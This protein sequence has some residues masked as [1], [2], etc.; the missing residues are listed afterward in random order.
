MAQPFKVIKKTLKV[1]EAFNF[2]KEF[3][4]TVHP[5]TDVIYRPKDVKKST[6]L[7]LKE[8]LAISG[9][10]VKD[11]VQYDAV[12]KPRNKKQLR[13]LNYFINKNKR[14]TTDSICNIH[15]MHLTLNWP[16]KVI[17]IPNLNVIGLDSDLLIEFNRLKKAATAQI[18]LEYDTTFNS[19]GYY[20][21]VSL[22]FKENCF[23]VTDC[24]TGIRN[25]I[26]SSFPK[27]KLLTC[28]SSSVC[29]EI[30]SDSS[31]NSSNTSQ[32]NSNSD[33]NSSN[34]S[35]L[36]S[37]KDQKSSD[38]SQL[39]SKL[40][41]ELNLKTQDT[42]EI[43]LKAESINKSLLSSTTLLEP[44]DPFNLDS[45]IIDADNDLDSNEV[46]SSKI[47]VN[48]A[49]EAVL[50]PISFKSSLNSKVYRALAYVKNNKVKHNI[51]LGI[52]QVIDEQ[53]ICNQIIPSTIG[54]TT[55]YACSCIERLNC[56]H[57]LAV[58]KSN[59]KDIEN[60]AKYPKAKMDDLVKANN[61]N[62][63]SGRKKRGHEKNSKPNENKII[64]SLRA[65]SVNEQKF[66]P[67]KISKQKKAQIKKFI[68]SAKINMLEI[69][70]KK[71]TLI[72]AD[73]L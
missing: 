34:A 54:K 19:T 71:T 12:N 26:K 14:F 55:K 72:E 56:V 49:F 38:A 2:I 43:N 35:Q 48:M 11:Y 21:S 23:V 45:S 6:V 9:K 61:N 30:I 57:I 69:V 40:I 31:Q 15:V 41:Y 66:P 59:D 1:D 32:L 10:P 46:V 68:L 20:V 50:E 63:L 22:D 7:T 52:Y 62:Q 8:N 4:K 5:Y 16:C 53:N 58:E 44:Y 24:E 70:F 64:D 42:D 28:N 27:I 17:T 37:N 36:N 73:Y 13:N 3:D 25:A 51:V 39:N 65:L 60:L 29:P 18:C 47:C 67:G 33:Q